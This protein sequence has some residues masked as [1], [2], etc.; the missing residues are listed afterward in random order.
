MASKSRSDDQRIRRGRVRAAGLVAALLV[1]ISGPGRFDEKVFDAYQRTSPR[2]LSQMRVVAV[3][4]DPESLRLIGPWPWSRYDLARLTDR[5][6]AARPLAIGYDMT[7]PELDRQTPAL[8]TSRYPEL[9]GATRA[10]VLALPSFDANFATALGTAPTVLGRAGVA[11]RSAELGEHAYD[12]AA[13]L[14]VDAQFDHPLPS[15]VM[16]WPQAL[17]SI[18]AIEETSLGHGLINGDRDADG[19]VRRVPAVGSL[20][21]AANTGFAVEL[22]R[23]ALGVDTVRVIA[24][25]GRLRGIGLGALTIPTGSDGRFRFRFGQM[26]PGAILSAADIFRRGFDARALAGKVVII[27]VTGAGG[28]DIVVT[29]LTPQ[30]YGLHVQAQAV[31]AILNDALLRRPHWAPLA[32]LVAGLLLA[33]LAILLL[34]RLRGLVPALA[35]PIAAVALVVAASWFAFAGWGLLLDPVPPILIAS[36]AGLAVLV[37]SFVE[38]ALAQRR[39]REALL[40]ERVGAARASGELDAA[41]DIQRGMLPS[42]ATL[43]GLDATVD[44]SAVL[45]PA[46]GV[47]GDFYDA[48]SLGNGRLA[49][50]VGDVTGKGVPAALFMAL[51]KALARAI[52]TAAADD[53]AEGF[54]NLDGE[55]SRDNSQDMFVTML[56]GV[57]DG[58]SGE[59]ALINAGHENP[60]V[61]R[62]DGLVEELPMQGGPPLCVATGF[63]YR[64]EPLH[65]APGNG[66]VITTD[67]VSEA[68]STSGAFFERT[69]LFAT[70]AALPRDW[71]A[72]DATAAIARDVRTFEAGAE[73]SDDLTALALRRRPA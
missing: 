70:L 56:F 6:A 29:P 26:P 52:M 39:L 30:A 53:P 61:V 20:N 5:I 62:A 9:K 49:F 63:P 72:I 60:I 73:P 14:P 35:L 58:A 22:A 17:A 33:G 59:V 42:P 37:A 10:A 51:S 4:I 40:Q 50:L 38:T 43:A 64:V 11:E 13:R 12:D 47:G 48:F 2:R 28:T 25:G 68:R 54:A 45:E 46:R 65:L 69:R 44:L 3:E 36:A 19:V 23:I 67:G 71:R 16:R 57:I 15:G 27:G 7:F 1:A 31:D 32:E 55:L 24:P 41:R 66:L 21:G 18:P 34:P 8:F